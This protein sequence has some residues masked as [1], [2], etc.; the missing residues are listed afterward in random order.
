MLTVDRK[1]YRLCQIQQEKGASPVLEK[2]DQETLEAVMPEVGLFPEKISLAMSYVPNQPFQNLYDEPT[3]LSRGTLFK[4]LD[5][6]FVGA[7]RR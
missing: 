3:A 5:F 4:S 1:K 6:P 2:F 7:K